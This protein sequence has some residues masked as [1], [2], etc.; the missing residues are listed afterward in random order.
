MPALQK[1]LLVVVVAVGNKS[2]RSCS[3]V[4]LPDLFDCKAEFRLFGPVTRR[5]GG[6]PR[7]P[8]GLSS[9]FW[10]GGD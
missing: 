8:P 1:E 9:F 10:G 7:L 5:D 2:S 6:Q 4:V 3:A